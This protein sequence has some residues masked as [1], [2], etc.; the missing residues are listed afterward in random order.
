[1]QLSAYGIRYP[2]LIAELSEEV[3]SQWILHLSLNLEQRNEPGR[4]AERLFRA[5]LS[6]LEQL[7]NNERV[8]D[9]I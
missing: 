2:S 1:M 4:A 6:L 8:L 9:L 5:P 3:T 7:L